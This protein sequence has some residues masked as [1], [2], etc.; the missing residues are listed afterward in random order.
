MFKKWLALALISSLAL[1][2][3]AA[4]SPTSGS[5]NTADGPNQIHLTDNTFSPDS[6]TIHQGESITLVSDTFTPH[7]IANGSWDQ[8][9]AKPGA[10]AGAPAVNNVEVKGNSSQSIGPFTTTGTFKLYCTI[11]PNMNLTIVVV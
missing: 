7:Y 4:C 3:L 2:A 10:E 6:I 11:H 1:L 9:S 8:G 5:N